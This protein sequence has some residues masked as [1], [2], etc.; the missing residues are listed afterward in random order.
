MRWKTF[1]P[2]CSKF[3]QETVY[4]IS[5]E[6]PEFY[7]RYDKKTLWSLFCKRSFNGI[8]LRGVL[9]SMR[10]RRIVQHITTSMDTSKVCTY[11]PIHMHVH[12][13]LLTRVRDMLASK[14]TISQRTGDGWADVL[15]LAAIDEMWGNG[16]RCWQMLQTGTFNVGVTDMIW[17]IWSVSTAY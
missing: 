2:F 12:N 17:I 16:K 15:V 13:T 6:S 8:V 11:R 3:I 14:L 7:R 1:T 9:C 10:V 5:S 4:Q